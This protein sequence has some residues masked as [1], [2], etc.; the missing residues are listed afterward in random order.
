MNARIKFSI[1]II[2][3]A[4]I[5]AFLPY[6]HNNPGELKP[7]E[8]SKLLPDDK[9]FI[10]VDKVARAIAF[11]DTSFQ[12]IDLRNTSEFHESAIPGSVNIPFPDL[13]NKDFESYFDQ[14]T[15][16]TIFYSNGDV[17]SAQAWTIC[18]AAGYQNLFIMKGG[19]NE[20]YETVMNSSYSGERISAKE[21]A[22]FEARY[23]ARKL[24]I[25]MNSLPDSLKTKYFNNKKSNRKKLDGGCG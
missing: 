10:S 16:K 7:S 13:L 2:T 5:T 21:N 17:L 23:K 12:I 18:T 9:Y 24:F 14:K 25:E 15:I 3:M 4:L 11:E 22:L 8:L 1:L 6:K 20:W 19:M